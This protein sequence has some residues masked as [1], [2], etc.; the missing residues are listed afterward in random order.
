MQI[1]IRHAQTLAELASL[2][3]ASERTLKSWIKRGKAVG[4]LPPLDDPGAMASWWRRNRTYRVPDALATLESSVPPPAA[5]A[6]PGAVIDDLKSGGNSPDDKGATREEQMPSGENSPPAR[7]SHATPPAPPP[8]ASPAQILQSA[9]EFVIIAQAKLKEATET[10]DA[11]KHAHCSRA[12]NHALDSLAKARANFEANQRNDATIVT[13]GMIDEQI[14]EFLGRL[15]ELLNELVRSLVNDGLSIAAAR[16][17]SSREFLRAR[18]AISRAAPFFAHAALAHARRVACCFKLV[19]RD[20]MEE[21]ARRFVAGFA[22]QVAVEG[23]L[24]RRRAE[25]A[26]NH[27]EP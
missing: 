2:Y 5:A 15:A 8:P 7:T 11:L 13:Q 10:G 14:Q 3:C 27:A 17:C 20:G 1:H 19:C 12:L 16:G 9:T 24:K 21:S 26:D 18:L 4:E 23:Q 25:A 22:N 6:T